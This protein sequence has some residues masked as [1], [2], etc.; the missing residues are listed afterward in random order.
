M[1]LDFCV[2]CSRTDDLNHHHLVPRSVGGLDDESNLITLCHECHGKIH[3]VERKPE[4]GELIR[5]DSS[6]PWRMA[7]GQGVNA[8]PNAK[9]AMS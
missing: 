2:A 8:T 1:R 3:N 9:A 4:L 5:L 7:S 6:A